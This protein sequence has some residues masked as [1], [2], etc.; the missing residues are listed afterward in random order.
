SGRV[1][2][3][4]LEP[5]FVILEEARFII[6]DE[7]GGGDVHGVDEAQP[8]LD[9]TFA[10]QFLD[11]VRDVHKFAAAGNLKP[12]MFRK[13]FHFAGFFVAGA[14]SDGTGL[15]PG[16]RLKMTEPFASLTSSGSPPIRE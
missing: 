13:R 14:D 7:H 12:K 10:H 1:R 5:D 11:G 16:L 4:F 6:V 8:F 9:A 2:R 3:E 15:T